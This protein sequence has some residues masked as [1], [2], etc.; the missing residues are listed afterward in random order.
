MTGRT[1]DEVS[2][3]KQTQSLCKEIKMRIQGTWIHIQALKKL[4][5]DTW[6]ELKMQMA[7]VKDRAGCGHCGNISAEADRITP[8]DTL[9]PVPL[10]VKGCG[11]AQLDRLRERH[12][13]TGHLAGACC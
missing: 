4:V 8:P 5:Y 1:R 9:D 6:W 2:V 7:K 3:N 13:P 10:P 11:T 12:T